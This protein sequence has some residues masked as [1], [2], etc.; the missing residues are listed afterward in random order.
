V[1]QFK[2]WLPVLKVQDLQAAIDF[3]T[4]ILGCTLHWRSPNDG[5]GENCMLGFGDAD[6]MLSTGSHLGGT[7]QFTGT[8]YLDMEGVEEFYERV[9]DRVELVWPLEV[10]EYG[11]REFGVRDPSGYTLA[12]SEAMPP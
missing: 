2:R 1:A 7:P 12:F 8:L 11:T 4:G 10:M 3:Y 6:L 9:K 5:G